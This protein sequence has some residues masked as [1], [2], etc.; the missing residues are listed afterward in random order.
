M[1]AS[2]SQVLEKAAVVTAAEMQTHSSPF[3]NAPKS[4]LQQL[5]E[6]VKKDRF[7]DLFDSEK[8]LLWW[9]VGWQ[10]CSMVCRLLE[11]HVFGRVVACAK[12]AAMCCASNVRGMCFLYG[13]RVVMCQWYKACLHASWSV[14]HFVMKH[15]WLCLEMCLI[16]SWNV[17]D[18]VVPVQEKISECRYCVISEPVFK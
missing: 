10:E 4:H 9:A 14:F 6:I 18:C 8:N 15:V 16:V 13:G 1:V 7:D 3:P 5:E 11:W 17:L 12:W 2:W